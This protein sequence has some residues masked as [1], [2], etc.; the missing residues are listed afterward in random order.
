MSEMIILQNSSYSKESKV[1]DFTNYVYIDINYGISQRYIDS[2]PRF[3]E[4]IL[5]ACKSQ[6]E[7]RNVVNQSNRMR[8]SCRGGV[9]AALNK[10]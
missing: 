6:V 7:A 3:I 10:G 1:L 8:L 5:N 9:E 4:R 2:F